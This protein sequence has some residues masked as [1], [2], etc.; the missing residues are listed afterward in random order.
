MF[1]FNNT[2]EKWFCN[3][4]VMR[5]KFLKSQEN[6]RGLIS[7][8]KD[9]NSRMTDF[10]IENRVLKSEKQQLVESNK[11]LRAKVKELEGKFKNSPLSESE[12][13]MKMIKEFNDKNNLNGRRKKKPKRKK[14]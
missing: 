2:E 10:I 8:L 9:R 13:R 14:F 11:V 5:R 12:E 3:W 7:D 6:V 1:V 4:V